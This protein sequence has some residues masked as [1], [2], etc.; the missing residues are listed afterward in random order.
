MIQPP[1]PKESR[2]V[3][4]GRDPHAQYREDI[5]VELQKAC[6]ALDIP[7]MYQ[8]GII[9]SPDIALAMFTLALFERVVKGEK[10]RAGRPPGTKSKTEK[11]S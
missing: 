1:K 3:V 8:P 4:F 11:S 6:T 7:I 9:N 2:R 5:R 10:K